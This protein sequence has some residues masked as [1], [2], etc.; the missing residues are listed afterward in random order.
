MKVIAHDNGRVVVLVD[1]LEF[2]WGKMGATGLTLLAAAQERY[3]FSI[4]TDIAKRTNK[5][6]PLR[7]EHG[8]FGEIAITLFEVH[9]QGLI[10]ECA[11][12]ENAEEFIE[13]I[14]AWGAEKYG[15]ARADKGAKRV[16]SSNLVVQFGSSASALLSNFATISGALSGSLREL[17]KIDVPSEV[18]RIAIRPDPERLS[19][20]M[21]GLLPD[22]TL[23]RRI[24]A[25]YDEQ[26]FYSVAPLPTK[27]HE[28]FLKLIE[29]NAL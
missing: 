8:S 17:Y 5:E 26:K 3:N 1:I 15:L 7:F 28:K 9:Q 24:F 29:D 20:R 19:P 14:S 4:V 6:E 25:P 10:A 23:E 27:A 11:T 18:S 12:T 13:D 22:F 21:Q 16:Y 2:G